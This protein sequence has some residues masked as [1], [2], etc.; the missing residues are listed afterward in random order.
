M[1]SEKCVP[2]ADQQ[3]AM[4]NEQLVQRIQMGIDVKVD[5]EQL[6][7][8]NKGYIYAM[9]GRYGFNSEDREDMAQ[10]GY[11]GL[12]EAVK[13]Y[14]ASID[15]S[16]IT[17]AGYWIRH[18]MRRYHLRDKK[19]RIP[20]NL[21]ERLLRYQKFKKSY[22][23]RFGK[24]PTD[25][26]ACCYLEIG[27]NALESL[28]AVALIAK[29]GS[30]DKTIDEAGEQTIKDTIRDPTD[31]YEQVF[32]DVQQEQLKEILWPLVDE[33]PGKAP[34]TLR[35]RY[36]EGLS[37][38]EAGEHMGISLEA[39]RQWQSKGLKELRKPSRSNQLKTFYDGEIYSSGIKG[40]GVGSFNRTWTSSTERIAMRISER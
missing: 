8:Q 40:N 25:D 12:C 5:L 23:L 3:N 11:L 27:R 36:Q 29:A 35:L 9:A 22:Q 20:D 26:Q 28:K 21:Y 18:K 33:L 2:A 13:S 10:E 34:E 1:S 17:Y 37:L 4:T 19:I 38:K 7:Q 24:E 15:C 16:F 30:I 32:D 31:P 6:W 14:D 39:V